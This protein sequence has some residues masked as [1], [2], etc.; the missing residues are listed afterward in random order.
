MERYRPRI[1]IADDHTL[2]AQ[3][4]RQL[5]EPE[6]EVV[7]IVNNGQALV[8]S[9]CRLNPDV[10]LVDIYMPVLNGLDA[11]ERIRS[12]KQT[13]KI[14]VLTM[15]FNPCLAAEAYKRGAHG[16]LS[17]SCAS[18]ELRIAIRTVFKGDRYVPPTIASD[19]FDFRMEFANSGGIPG[20]LT[21]RQ[22]QV[23]QI[24]AEGKSMKEAAMHLSVSPRTVPFTNTA[25]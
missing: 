23:V 1:V 16:F 7:A 18:E 25:S 17:K 8:D 3:L 2:V 10:V 6:F 24:L 20:M 11:C 19:F 12:I 14:I 5:L 21:T 15:D 22:K 4:C 9:V 13:V